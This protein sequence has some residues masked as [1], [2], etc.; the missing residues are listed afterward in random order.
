MPSI[1]TDFIEEEPPMLDDEK[2]D[3]P[4]PKILQKIEQDIFMDKPPPAMKEIIEEV[5]EPVSVSEPVSKPVKKKR[6]MTEAQKE[7]L[8]KNREKALI[9]R[10]ARAAEKKELQELEGLKKAKQKAELKAYVN[11]DKPLVQQAPAPTPAPAPA[12]EPVVKF[13]EKIVYKEV[14]PD[15]ESKIQSAISEALQAHDSARKVRKEKKKLA[16]KEEN[17]NDQLLDMVF[18]AQRQR[19]VKRFGQGGSKGYF[20]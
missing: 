3:V 12:P 20:D 17:H 1:T 11:D 6:V 10:R 9:T 8:T 18:H 19:P 15:I 5:V 14:L 13:Q 2:D 16:Q 7:Q 4:E